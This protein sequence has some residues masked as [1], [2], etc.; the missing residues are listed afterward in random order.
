MCRKWPFGI[1]IS[2]KCE[3]INKQQNLKLFFYWMIYETSAVKYHISSEVCNV[4]ERLKAS[5]GKKRND[6][7]ANSIKCNLIVSS[8]LV[9]F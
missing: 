6:F 7:V 8:M 1:S 2:N 3:T 4:E 9:K 5:S